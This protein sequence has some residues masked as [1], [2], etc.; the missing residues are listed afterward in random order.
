MLTVSPEL[1]NSGLGKNY[2]QQAEVHAGIGPT[3]IVMTVI[4]LQEELIAWYKRHGYIDNGERTFSV[5][6]IHI[7]IVNSLWNLSC[8]KKNKF[9]I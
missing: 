7:S 6:D 3:K 4:S 1:Q 9:P 5:S 2:L 8:S